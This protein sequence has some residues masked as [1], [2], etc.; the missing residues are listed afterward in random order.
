MTLSETSTAKDRLAANES[1]GFDRLL[2]VDMSQNRGNPCTGLGITT[3]GCEMHGTLDIRKNAALGSG[4]D[5]YQVRYED[6]AG[7]SFAGSMNGDDL[8]ELLYHKLALPLT[9]DELEM[10]FARLVR[11]GHL[12]F[13]EIAVKDSELA[14][15]GLRYR[16][17]DA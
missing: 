17:A 1:S 2:E 14:G 9:D 6:L 7:N 11:E 3:R 12:R 8:R 16:E 10:D 13:E 15:A 5:I 4:V